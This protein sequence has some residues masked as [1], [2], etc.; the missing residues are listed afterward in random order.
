MINV[1]LTCVSV[2]VTSLRLITKFFFIM[3]KKANGKKK[4]EEKKKNKIK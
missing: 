1:D 4:K 2:K 3:W